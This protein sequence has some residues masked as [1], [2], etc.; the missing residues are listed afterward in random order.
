MDNQIVSTL[1][2]AFME[3]SERLDEDSAMRDEIR[4]IQAKLPPSQIGKYGQLQEWLTDWEELEPGHR[5]VSP[6]WGVY[7]GEVITPR[8]PDLAQAARVSLDRRSTGGCGWSYTHKVGIWARLLAPEGVDHETTRYLAG[9]VLPNLFSRCG[10]AMQVDGTFGMVGSIGEA[11]VQSHFGSIDLL[12]AS[13]WPSGSV[14]GFRARGGFTVD[15]SWSDGVV[16]SAVIRSSVGGPVILRGV[17]VGAVAR[18]RDRV[19]FTVTDDGVRFE[20]MPG[21][22]YSIRAR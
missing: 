18:G 1:L 3:W 8:Q 15:A 5:H 14:T 11:L 19:P 22:V 2:Q 9:N 6:L 16:R 21:G 12:P 17:S 20:T 7:P 4:G 10:R 13:P